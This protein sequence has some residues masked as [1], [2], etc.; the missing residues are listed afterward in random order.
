MTSDIVQA[1][2][3][4]PSPCDC[5]ET[6]A[7]AAVALQVL[8]NCASKREKEVGLCLDAERAFYDDGGKPYDDFGSKWN[9]LV[10]QA[11]YGGQRWLDKMDALVEEATNGEMA[12]A[13]D[14]VESMDDYGMAFIYHLLVDAKSVFDEVEKVGIACWLADE[15]CGFRLI[16]PVEME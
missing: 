12:I 16:N 10:L 3:F 14:I 5:D 7:L 9:W 6:Y 11:F 2:Y 4:A 8:E 1:S 15:R 13:W